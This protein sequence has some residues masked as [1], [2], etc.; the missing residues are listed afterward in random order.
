MA[1]PLTHTRPRV[2]AFWLIFAGV[3]GWYAAFQLTVEKFH[4]YENPG[5]A[6]GC[7]FSLLVQCTENLNSWQGA[8]FGFPN[9]IIGLTAWMAPIVVGF[10]ILAGAR[11]ARWFWI[12]FWGGMLF[13]F[14]FVAWLI[15]QS[16]YDL[17]TLCPW[18]MV[19]WSVTIPSFY[20]VTVHLLRSGIVPVGKKT[21][22]VFESLMSWVP[23][24]AILSYALVALLAQL[25]LDWLSYL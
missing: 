17:H 10:A 12:L 15:S 24:I 3:V 4:A 9:P 11:F 2:L 8:V 14:C 21:R 22:R 1:T 18:C 6:A 20:A 7:D 25:K 23:L 16:I 5:S 13:A 19:T